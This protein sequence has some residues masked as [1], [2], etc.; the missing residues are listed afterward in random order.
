MDL[1]PE[2]E[3][4]SGRIDAAIRK[5]IERGRFIMGEELRRF[6]EEFARYI[7]VGHAVGVNSGS[8][9]LFLALRA[10]GVGRGDEVITA[11]HSFISTA[12]AI[13]R[14][15]ATPV[16]VDIDPSTY[17]LN[18]SRAESAITLKTKAIIPI[19]LYGHP[20]DMPAVMALARKHKLH[21]IEDACQAQGAEYGGKKAGSF[22]R[23]GCFSFYPTK[24]L[25]AYGDGGMITTDNSIL[26]GK[27]RRLRNYGETQKYFYDQE[28]INSRLD[29]L[30][31]AILRVKLRSLD[32]RNERRRRLAALYDSL[33]EDAG[34][35]TPRVADGV[36]HAY[37]LYVVRSRR[38]DSL[39]RYLLEN[40]I[41][42]LIHYP[43]PIHRQK[44]YRRFAPKT[45]DLAVTEECAKSVLSLPL[46]PELDPASVTFIA[47]TV[48]R[49][50]R[51]AKS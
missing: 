18:V 4:M 17:C 24:N 40:G 39:R 23:M 19:H 44:T 42:T 31:A 36:K 8:D 15:G 34:V 47:E 5:V 33:L 21:V 3:E 45:E 41:D 9:A 35:V 22:G 1:R 25:G 27:L 30:Q 43:V 46:Y 28:G 16:F 49:F 12:D 37:Y 32:S 14:N 10:L 38:R 48:R 6:E 29:E 2:Y 20:A 11:S 13:T 50:G 51:K 7:G 26:A